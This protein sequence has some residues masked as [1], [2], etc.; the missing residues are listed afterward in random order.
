MEKGGKYND[1]FAHHNAE[2]FLDALRRLLLSAMRGCIKP[3]FDS[4][5]LS[6]DFRPKRRGFS[7]SAYDAPVLFRLLHLLAIVSFV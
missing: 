2:R 3:R 6:H 1:V 5:K 7:W 4:A